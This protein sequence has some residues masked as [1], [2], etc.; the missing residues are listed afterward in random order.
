MKPQGAVACGLFSVVTIFVCG[1]V[2]AAVLPKETP[3]PPKADAISA[4]ALN[5]AVRA[6]LAS[7]AEYLLRSV[8]TNFLHYAAPP[9]SNRK[10]IGWDRIETN[11]VHYRWEEY[12]APKYEHIYEA[13][14][15]FAVGASGSVEAR[16][17]GKVKRRRVVGRKK[18]GTLTRKRLV[19]D[20][21]GEVVRTHRK[22]IGPQ[23]GQG[24]ETWPDQLPGD[25]ALARIR[26]D[27]EEGPPLF[28]V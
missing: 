26:L 20:P 7:G 1:I 19:L 17:I 2:Q 8:E 12:E 3:C 21:D 15:T 13:Y 22:G 18:V 5:V 9:I 16:K 24:T 14:E 23:Y 4:G 11:H 28:T 6:S 25:N 10:L 27:G